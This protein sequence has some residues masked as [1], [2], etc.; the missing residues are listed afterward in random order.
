MMQ[1]KEE[2]C[3]NSG[4]GNSKHAK[5][6]PRQTCQALCSGVFKVLAGLSTRSRMLRV[7]RTLRGGSRLSCL[8]TP[9]V[10]CI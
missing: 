1:T 10:T 8:S 9:R 7:L 2:K 4:L 5:L 6:V 3:Y